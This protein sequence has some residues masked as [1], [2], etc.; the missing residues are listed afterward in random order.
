M[1]NMKTKK[2]PKKIADRLSRMEGQIKGIRK[3][4]EEGHS[5]EK[6]LIQVSAAKEAVA[7]LGAE[8]LKEEIVECAG[9]GKKIDEKM[10]RK[11]FKFK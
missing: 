6:V 11:I 2:V 3:M 8:I 9:K 4:I 1:K 5:C 7:M 10:I